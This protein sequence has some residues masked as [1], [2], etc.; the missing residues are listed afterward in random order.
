M[1]YGKY[2]YFL[3]KK[4]KEA[5]KK[6]KII[7]V[8]EIKIRPKIEEHDYQTKLRHIERF[9]KEGNK[10]KITMMFH[11]REILHQELGTK[12][13]DRIL[14]DVSSIGKVE[15]AAKLEGNNMIMT[16]APK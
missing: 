12:I 15:Q 4:E 6:H 16:L 5:K 8:K 14:Q 7:E 11:G 1:D 10:V 3:Q 2:K 9:L 13:L